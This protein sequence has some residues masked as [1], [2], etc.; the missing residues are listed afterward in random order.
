MLLVVFSKK[1][2]RN[3]IY[4]DFNTQTNK[5]IIIKIFILD[6]FLDFNFIAINNVLSLQ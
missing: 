4:L 3:D 5:L 2:K 6:W 1:K